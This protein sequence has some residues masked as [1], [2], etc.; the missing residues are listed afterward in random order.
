MLFDTG[1]IWRGD[2]GTPDLPLRLTNNRPIGAERELGDSDQGHGDVGMV[3]RPLEEVYVAVFIDATTVKVVCYFS[4]VS[5]SG[6]KRLWYLL[7]TPACL[8]RSVYLILGDLGTRP[9]N[10]QVNVY[11]RGPA[12]NP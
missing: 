10:H 6:E 4:R 1:S 5:S 8:L 9:H 7:G 12:C 3:E 2:N 11:G